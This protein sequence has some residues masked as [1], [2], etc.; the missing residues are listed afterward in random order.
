MLRGQVFESCVL[1][2]TRLP[3]GKRDRTE[4]R[5]RAV[6]VFATTQPGQ[7]YDHE[8]VDRRSNGH[9]TIKNRYVHKNAYD[10]VW[11]GKTREKP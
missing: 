8:K 5:S 6:R 11:A 3:I 7:P 4:V 9:L 10:P 1:L 2:G